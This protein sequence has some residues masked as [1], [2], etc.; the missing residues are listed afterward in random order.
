MTART[1]TRWLAPAALALC[2][3]GGATAEPGEDRYSDLDNPM[4]PADMQGASVL[5]VERYR[6]TYALEGCASDFPEAREPDAGLAAALKGAQAFSHKHKGLGLLVLH[7]GVPIHESYAGGASVTSTSASASMMKSLIALLYGI[8]IRDGIIGS[9][10]DPIGDY[11]DE[12]AQDPRGDITL[13]QML[14]MSSGLA[15]SDFMKIIFAPDIGAEAVKLELAGEPGSEFSYN[16]A[17]TKLLTLALDRALSAQGKGG[18]LEYLEAE[19]WCPIGN[20]PAR[21]WVDPAGKARG[22]AGMQATL[23]DWARVGELI[24]NEGRAGGEQVVPESWIAAMASPSDANAQYGLHV[25]LG[26]EHTP[27]RAYSKENPVKVPHSEPFEAQDIV[28]FDGF[29]GQ[30]VYVLPSHD[31]TVVRIG[32]VDLTYDDSRIPNLLARAVE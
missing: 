3:A 5:D 26:R 1:M 16:N 2:L 13:E 28:Y 29:G 4:T 32:E 15:P 9:V 6:P 14:T 20:G 31:L 25:W 23:R 17:V 22:Y 30:R 24:R 12:W 19:L 8:A 21:V 27:Q 11:L 18:V 10:D 7:D